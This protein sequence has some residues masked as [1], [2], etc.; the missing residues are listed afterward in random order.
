MSRHKSGVICDDATYEAKELG[1]LLG[2]TREWVLDHVIDEGCPA[3]EVG[4]LFLVSGLSYRLWIEGRA[5][6]ASRAERKR[7]GKKPK[8]NPLGGEAEG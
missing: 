7:R 3:A 1:E 4:M 2:R 8:R 5:E 6:I